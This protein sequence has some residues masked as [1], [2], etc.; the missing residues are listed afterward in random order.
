MISKKKLQYLLLTQRLHQLYVV[1]RDIS[2]N[3]LFK[4]TNKADKSIDFYKDKLLNNIID[5]NKIGDSK[6]IAENIIDTAL[7]GQANTLMKKRSKIIQGSVDQTV[8]DY[9]KILSSRFDS[10]AYKLKAKIEAES[11]LSDSEIKKKY[12]ELYRKNAKNIVRDALHTNQSRMSFL[13][14]LDKG[15]KYKVWMNGRA[16]Q[17]RIWHRANFI[18]SV[19]I[20]DYFII[21]GSYR[22][23]MMYP[24][25]LAGGAE[26][27][28]NCRCWLRYTNRTPSN[29]KSKSSFNIHPNSYLHGK[30]KSSSNQN[31][32]KITSKIKNKIT[33]TISNIGS[34]LIKSISW[35]TN[36]FKKYN[37]AKQVNNNGNDNNIFPKT[38]RE[39]ENK[40]KKEL[41]NIFSDETIKLIVTEWEKRIG[42][43][44][45][46]GHVFN[47]VSGKLVG[48]PLK[49]GANSITILRPNTF[50]GNLAA[51]HNHT[52]KGFNAPSGEDFEVCMGNNWLDYFIAL[53]SHEIWVIKAKGYFP[54]E[55][56]NELS[57]KINSGL[58]SIK[59]E[60][61]CDEGIPSQEK[62]NVMN[63]R[64]SEFVKNYISENKQYDI[65]VYQVVL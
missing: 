50:E 33:R 51:F 1:K 56:I 54:N 25:D 32:L 38:R 30:N 4:H 59:F 39:V 65:E 13:H 19:P 8:G 49:G 3:H 7:Q 36:R 40:L 9:S 61:K 46:H 53:S 34:K 5:G 12:G 20:D 62:I 11:K 37:R 55:L 6:K 17:H 10:D 15:Y 41:S 29:L 47:Y 23:E 35:G 24:G 18:E 27:V 14:A 44:I 64:A 43:E 16:R 22:T 60:V 48:N 57:L 52:K 42:A 45:E 28:A 31:S 63:K 21:T 2:F 58:V 26:N